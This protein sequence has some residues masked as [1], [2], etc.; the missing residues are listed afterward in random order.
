MSG[1][2][3]WILD[4]WYSLGL[5]VHKQRYG[6][7]EQCYEILFRHNFHTFRTC[8]QHGEQTDRWRFLILIFFY[9]EEPNEKLSYW[10]TKSMFYC[11]SYN[12]MKTSLEKWC[13]FVFPTFISYQLFILITFFFT[14]ICTLHFFLN[15]IKG[16]SRENSFLR[17]RWQPTDQR[18]T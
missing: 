1:P 4:R 3:H 15:L 11:Q 2:K 7:G 12:T 16:K 13:I 17:S 8:N 9:M 6:P 14:D 18:N 5:I 10:C